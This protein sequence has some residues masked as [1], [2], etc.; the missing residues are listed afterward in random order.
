MYDA[1]SGEQILTLA[2]ATYGNFVMSPNGDMLVYILSGARNWLTLWN[3]SLVKGM[4]DGTSGTLAWQWRPRGGATLDWKSGIQWNVTVPD[5]V[6]SQ[7]INQISDV[8]LASTAS[9]GVQQTWVD[10]AYSTSTGE[11]LWLKNRTALAGDVPLIFGGNFPRPFGEGVYVMFAKETL[12]WYGF[13]IA[14]GDALWETVPMS[15]AWAT[16]PA[17]GVV[18]YGKLFTSGYDGTVHCY[19]IKTGRHLWDYYGGNAG[20]EAPY[21]HYPFFGGLTVADGKVYAATN[22]HSPGAPIWKGERLHAID[23]ETGKGIWNVSGLWSGSGGGRGAG[24]GPAVVADGYLLSLNGNDNQIYCFGKGQTATTVSASPD[25][26]AQGSTVLIAGTI[27]DQSPGVTSLG[28]PAA[29]TPAIADAVMTDWMEYLYMQQPKPAQATGVKVHI[30]AIDPNNNFQEIG[31][32]TSDTDGMFGITWTP[33][34][35]GLYKVTATFDG[36]NSYFRSHA[37]TMFAVSFAPAATVVPPTP[38]VTPPPSQ[39]ASPT[40]TP[41]QQVSPSP[42]QAVAP[43]TSAEPTTTYIAVGIAVVVILAAAV[44]LALRKRK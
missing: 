10:I 4:L 39:T 3:S 19:D 27:T 15:N 23:V 36:S 35:P 7:S 29:G 37:S 5:V 44:A 43:P 17:G 21:G 30:T 1:F 32:V 13:S 20:L 25:V 14:T 9:T 2:N 11:Q 12:K 31:T 28:V 42:T 40:S 24:M 16:Y 34:V 26:S 41:V 6:G 33:P 18:A 22:E 38:I 8:I